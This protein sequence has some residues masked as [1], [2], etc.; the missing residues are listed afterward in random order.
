MMVQQNRNAIVSTLFRNNSLLL[1]GYI[2]SNFSSQ[3][4]GLQSIIF[5]HTFQSNDH[6]FQT[7]LFDSL[8]RVKW[9]HVLEVRVDQDVIEMKSWLHILQKS[10]NWN[11]TTGCTLGHIGWMDIL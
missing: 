8:L 1:L 10:Q 9:L 11:L 3:T 4:V 5:F 2:V 6:N 7:N